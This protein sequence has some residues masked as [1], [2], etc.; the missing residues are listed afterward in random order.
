[1][2]LTK[3]STLNAC[4]SV[5]VC[6]LRGT[7]CVC[8]CI[9]FVFS[10]PVVDECVGGDVCIQSKCDA[11]KRSCRSCQGMLIRIHAIV[12]C[13]Y[14]CGCM[15]LY[16][17][18]CSLV[19]AFV[20]TPVSRTIGCRVINSQKSN[21]RLSNIFVCKSNCCNSNSTTAPSNYTTIAYHLQPYV[22]PDNGHVTTETA[23]CAHMC[24]GSEVVRWYVCVL[25][26]CVDVGAWVWGGRARRCRTGAV[27]QSSACFV[28]RLNHPRRK[29]ST[30]LFTRSSR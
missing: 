14:Y 28:M 29:P 11:A 12:P 24:L 19:R 16:A 26:V 4:H 8:N 17:S 21:V 22:Q 20:C 2:I 15:C 18:V 30:P 25:F 9:L 23:A 7:A 1:M 10:C 13:L 6:P 3:R 27:K 5:H